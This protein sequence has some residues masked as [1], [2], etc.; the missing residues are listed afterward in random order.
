M[1]CIIS[2]DDQCKFDSNILLEII[3][4]CYYGNR[5]YTYH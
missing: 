2:V 4:G 3:P 5:L 1:L